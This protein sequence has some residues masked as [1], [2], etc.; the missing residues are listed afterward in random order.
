MQ[1][2]K[3]LYKIGHGPSSSHTLGPK[4]AAEYVENKYKDADFFVVT[5][6]G[7]LALTGSTTGAGATFSTLTTFGFKSLLVEI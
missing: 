2:L 4:R 5:I 7:S 1:S 6:Y 3:E